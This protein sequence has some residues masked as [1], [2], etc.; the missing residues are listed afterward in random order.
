MLHGKNGQA[1]ACVL[2]DLNTQRDFFDPSGACPVVGTEDLHR[3]LRRV[4]AW[5]KRNQVPIVSSMASH[6]AWECG[7][8]GFAL[9]C[10]EGSVGQGKLPFTL[11]PSRT[12]I[13][14]DN[15]LAI[16]IDLFHK[17]Q[18]VIFPQRTKDLFANPK[19]D[20]F[21]TQ[22]HATEFILF[23]AL[24]EHEVKAVALGLLARG[25]RVT[26]LCDACG[27]WNQT[28]SEICLRQMQAKG[29]TLLDVDALLLRQL[30]RRIRYTPTGLV[31][32]WRSPRNSTRN[33][34]HDG[35]NGHDGTNG[36]S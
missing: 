33:N 26:I 5:A 23:G 3:R 25:K 22:L 35:S 4:V 18:Q 21:L 9:H 24:I 32:V 19:A 31:Q 14:G 30:P 27:G 20:R 16:S 1:R 11:M 10:I 6:R 12:Y 7:V 17:H 28:V 8:R 2:V 13:E 15:T 34:G 29:A 36:H